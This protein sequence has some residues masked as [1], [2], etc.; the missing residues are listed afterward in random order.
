MDWMGGRV[1]EREIKVDFSSVGLSKWI[2]GD[3][4]C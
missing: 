2:N 1:M 4:F 3:A